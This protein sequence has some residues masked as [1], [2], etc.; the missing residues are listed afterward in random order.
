[1]KV[2]LTTLNAKYIHSSLALR[3]LEKFCKKYRETDYQIELK[4]F[5]INE[6]LDQIMAEIY[7]A[8]PDVIAFSTYIWNRDDIFELADKLKKVQPEITIVM[9][10]PEVSFEAFETMQKYQYIDFIIKGEG[11]ETLR[12]LLDVL[13]EGNISFN[14]IDGLLYRV[15]NREKNSSLED[16]L[17]QNKETIIEIVENQDRTLIMDLDKIPRPY[18]VSDL[19]NLS[20]KIIYYEATR[21]CPFNCSYC[22]SSTLKGVRSFSMERIKEDLIFFIENDIP[23]VK[24]VDRSFNADKRKA[25]E[26]FEFLLDNQK[27]TNFHFEIIADRLDREVIELLKKAPAGLFQFEI[28]VQST[29][30]KSLKLIH[31]QMDLEK[32]AANVIELRKSNNINLHLDLI[33]GLPAED[34]GSF[35]KSFNQVYALNPHVLQLGFLKLLKGSEVRERAE[36]FSYKYSSLPPYEVLKNKDISYAEL[37]SL[38]AVEDLLDK[39]HNSGVFEKSLK[40]IFYQYKNRFFDFFKDFSIYFEEEN[41]HRRSHSRKSLYDILYN[42]YKSHIKN[43][44]K[45]FAEFL[46]YDLIF[47]NPGAKLPFWAEDIEIKGF[48]DIRYNFLDK[49]KNIVRY[50]PAYQGESVREILK[51][52][53]FE[54]FNIDVVSKLAKSQLDYHLLEKDLGDLSF[55]EKIV[56]FDYGDSNKKSN[57]FLLENFN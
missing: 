38:K 24:F 42:F 9:G 10:G 12:E 4:E 29:N 3:Y 54:V 56:L 39:Y 50:L 31:R 25:L 19:K 21:G 45:I 17:K 1:M 43:D 41:L 40:F 51:K 20:N 44:L 30:Q 55:S 37:L 36:E 2:L 18:T 35:K 23:Q 11:E 32:L 14:N 27:N 33:A 6:H 7:R 28:G 26:I 53:S 34:Y 52:V 13:K 57:A 48:K 22:L 47:N 15:E 46:K 16:D 8:Q 5:S 49:D